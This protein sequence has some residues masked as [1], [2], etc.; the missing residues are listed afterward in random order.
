MKYSTLFS[1]FIFILSSISG[2]A[3]TDTLQPGTGGSSFEVR[4][5]TYDEIWKAIVRSA[6]RSLTIVE[7]NKETGTLKA[8]NGA[9]MATWGEVVGVFV[10]P[11]SNG[12]SMYTIEVQ[13]LKRSRIQLTGQDWTTTMITGIKTELDQ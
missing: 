6:G 8:E 3:T 4:G 2:C 1:V 5:K 9:G 7:S 11:A 13:S 12:A 10:R